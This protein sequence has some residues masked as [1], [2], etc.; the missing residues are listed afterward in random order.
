MDFGSPATLVE[1]LFSLPPGHLLKIRAGRMEPPSCYYSPESRVDAGR[2][3][4]LSRQSPQALTAEIE[5]LNHRRKIPKGLRTLG[6]PTDALPWVV[7]RAL[8]DHSH[9]TNPRPVTREDY[10]RLLAD[11]MI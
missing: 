4:S 9:P 10:A 7:E 11:V 5:A 8:E 1:N 6:V 3:E 2:Y